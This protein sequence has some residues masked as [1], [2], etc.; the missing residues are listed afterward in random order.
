MNICIKK[1]DCQTSLW[2]LFVYGFWS[3]FLEEALDVVHPNS[4]KQF[5]LSFKALAIV[6]IYSCFMDSISFE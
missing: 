6:L 1:L 4:A 5:R 3:I 2:I